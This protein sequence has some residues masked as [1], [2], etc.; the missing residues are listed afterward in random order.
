MTDLISQLA[1]SI[2]AL[3]NEKPQS[4][5]KEEIEEVVKP[6]VDLAYFRGR[7]HSNM[8]IPEPEEAEVTIVDPELERIGKDIVAAVEEDEKYR[9]Q[10]ETY[11]KSLTDAMNTSVYGGP[12]VEDREKYW[13]D[14]LNEPQA[15]L[16]AAI[17]RLQERIVSRDAIMPLPYKDVSPEMMQLMEFANSERQRLYDITGIHPGDDVRHSCAHGFRPIEGR[18]I[19]RCACCGLRKYY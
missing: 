1:D 8:P 12:T 4:P 5:R 16:G 14:K 10:F 15:S 11:K 13:A 17:N 19:L 2:I 18:Y 9:A 6:W 7:L 3:I